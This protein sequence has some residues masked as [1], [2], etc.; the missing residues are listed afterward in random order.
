MAVRYVALGSS[1]AAGLGLGPRVPGSP[2][3]CMRSSNGYPQVLARRAGYD[4]VDRSCSGATARHVLRGGQF[5]QKPQLDA[6]TPE[7]EL[8]TLTAGGNDVGYVGDLTLMALRRGGG[9]RFQAAVARVLWKGV[10]PVEGRDF[11]QL[12]E[13]LDVILVEIRRRARGAPGGGGTKKRNKPQHAP[14]IRRRALRARVV[15]V[16]Y[17]VILPQQAPYLQAGIN[18]EEAALMRAVG[19][20]LAEVTRAAAEGAGVLLADMARLSIGHDCCSAEPWVHGARPGKGAPFH[21]TIAG[22]EATAGEIMRVLAQ[23]G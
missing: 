9:S 11:A 13:N 14:E 12:R 8:V 21:P 20:R 18:E 4:L 16:T 7:T 17:P 22:A 2:C 15:A 1:F 19:E 5:F 6:V 3:L 10:R 23:S